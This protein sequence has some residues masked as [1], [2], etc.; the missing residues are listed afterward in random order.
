MQHNPRAAFGQW[1]THFGRNLDHSKE[2]FEQRLNAWSSNLQRHF[3]NQ[4]AEAQLN[5]LADLSD[6]EFRLS[7]LGQRTRSKDLLR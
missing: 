4:T 2:E 5:G 6:E 3:D 7:Y 1:L